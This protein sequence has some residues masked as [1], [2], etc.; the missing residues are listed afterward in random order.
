MLFFVLLRLLPWCG[1]RASIHCGR[2]GGTPRAR[3]VRAARHLESFAWLCWFAEATFICMRGAGGA[4]RDQEGRA[5]GPKVWLLLISHFR[6]ACEDM[7]GER[8]GSFGVIC[9]G[10]IS[11]SSKELDFGS[12]EGRSELSVLETICRSH[13]FSLS[14]K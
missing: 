3:N 11:G 13:T 6:D 7:Y 5:D 1:G 4:P 14:K 12:F 8:R 2:D 9:K 10:G